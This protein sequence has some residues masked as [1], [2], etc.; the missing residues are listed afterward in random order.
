VPDESVTKNRKSGKGCGKNRKE[1]FMDARMLWSR[2]RVVVG[3][4][5]M[6]IGAIDP[7]EGSLIIL[8]GSGM[9]TLG[10]ILGKSRRRILLYWVWVFI[11]IAA[12]VGV[13]WVLSALGGL[14]GTS[15]R[16]LWW[17]IVILPYPV[18]WIMGIIGIVARLIEF[19]KTSRQQVQA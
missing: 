9:V 11:L 4:I 16:S 7:L 6:F 2:I 10:T 14:G 5:A 17:G 3:S 15:G 12:G 8:V 13:M 19:I 1:N 18:G